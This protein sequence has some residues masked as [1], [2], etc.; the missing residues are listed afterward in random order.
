MELKGKITQVLPLQQGI[1]QRTGNAWK[2]QEYVLETYDRFPR[3]V[4]FNFFNEAVDTY[5]L[6]VGD[7]INLSFDLESRS[8]VGRDGVERWSTDVRGWKAEKI[9]PATI[10]APAY[11]APVGQPVQPAPIGQP[12]PV[13]GQFPQAPA[14]AAPN[15][16]E[17]LPF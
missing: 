15:P 9:D 13:V 10:A 17:D 1:G 11:G 14:P 8:Y 12:A 6:Q 2:K 16:T 7:D 5:P 3:K 4:L